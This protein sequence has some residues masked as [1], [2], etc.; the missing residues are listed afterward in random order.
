M[1]PL[2]QSRVS[3]STDEYLYEH[4]TFLASFDRS[5]SQQ[6]REAARRQNGEERGTTHVLKQ[7][8]PDNSV[9]PMVT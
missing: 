2:T 8:S 1:F 3:A 4:S 6:A 7:G 9:I 5:I